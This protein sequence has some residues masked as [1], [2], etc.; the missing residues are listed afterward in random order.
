MT[1]KV[2]DKV[3]FVGF[4]RDVPAALS[5]LDVV[6]FSSLW[7]GTPLTS[8]EAL[9]MGKPIVSTD[10]D[11]LKDILTDGHDAIL[12]SRRNGAALGEAIVG[13]LQ[14]AEER[15]RLGAHARVT[16]ARYDI[17]LFVRK[18]ERLY[19]LLHETSRPTKRA[20]A[21]NADLSFLADGA[22]P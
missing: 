17:D 14:N 11:G 9:A 19:E 18:L 13:L 7:E 16:G 2:G 5:A 20:G 22:R 1:I 21:V 10:A 15:Q 12:V 4:V 6:V 3:K 8:F